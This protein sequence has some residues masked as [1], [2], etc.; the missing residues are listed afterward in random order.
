[1]YLLSHGHKVFQLVVELK[2][3]KPNKVFSSPLFLKSRKSSELP[4]EFFNMQISRPCRELLN[5][6][7]WLS[8]KIFSKF[9][10]TILMVMQ[11]EYQNVYF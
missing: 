11:I 10:K 9:P 4:G 6:C 7:L 1:M 8:F 3:L 2:L 5:I